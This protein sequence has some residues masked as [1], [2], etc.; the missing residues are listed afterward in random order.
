MKIVV[1]G[2]GT[3]T[4]AVA[5]VFAE[6]A[7]DVAY[8]VP[9]SDNG[10]STSEILRL[11]GGPAIGDARSRLVRLID[12]SPL[13]NLLA[14]RLSCNPEC[15]ARDWNLIVEGSHPLWV[16]VVPHMK[17]MYRAFLV[18]VH[19]ELLKRSTTTKPINLSQ[20]SVGNLLLTG[21]RLF[22]GTLDA[23]IEFVLYTTLVPRRY[24]VLPC[25]N[26]ISSLH[27]AAQL[28]NNTVVVGQSAISHPSDSSSNIHSSPYGSV[29][30]E[31]DIS[32]SFFH[33]SLGR[34]HLN[35]AKSG[36]HPL[37][38][39][40]ERVYYVNMYGDEIHPCLSPRSITAL[41]TA[42]ALVCSVGSLYTSIIP[43]LLLRGFASHLPKRCILMLNGTED[44]ETY[45]MQPKD[46]LDAVNSALSYS[47]GLTHALVPEF[48]ITGVIYPEGC[49]IG[50]L[51]QTHNV[52]CESAICIEGEYNLGSLGSALRRCL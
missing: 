33:P 44:R 49:A 13:R 19:A 31:E 22:F 46:Y 20:A 30:V 35:F 14:F 27:I 43:I 52:Q 18:H 25:L 6:T 45:G 51:A 23:A 7:Y 32:L 34:S 10:G 48:F 15:A 36:S 12:P 17:A 40:I 21:A 8:I 29:P 24:N 50:N 11:F 4:N 26:S 41:Q 5:P 47:N 37:P 3:G 39:A 28:K 16:E 38:S 1:V 42:D 2:G 9:V